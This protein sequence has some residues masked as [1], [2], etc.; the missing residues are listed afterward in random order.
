MSSLLASSANTVFYFGTPWLSFFRNIVNCCVITGNILLS[1]QFGFC[2]TFFF[3]LYEC[4]VLHSWA[5]FRQ[6]LLCILFVL[7]LSMKILVMS[8]FYFLC[9][10][11]NKILFFLEHFTMQRAYFYYKS[12]ISKLSKPRQHA[13]FP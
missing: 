2:Y 3:S 9:T 5:F 1:L 4:F 11:I 6:Y 7:S 10:F 12:E 8:C 13:P